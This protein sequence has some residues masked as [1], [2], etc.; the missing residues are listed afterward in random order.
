MSLPSELLL[1]V[2]QKLNYGFIY[3]ILA[4][5]LISTTVGSATITQN[6]NALAVLDT[7]TTTGSSATLQSR[8]LVNN[9]NGLGIIAKFTVNFSNGRANTTQLIG[10]GD[11]SD[12]GLFFGYNG[13]DFGIL[14]RR[15][16]NDTWIN[17]SN[18][19]VSDFLVF[20]PTKGNTYQIRFEYR[21]LGIIEFGIED[22]AGKFFLV[23][24][25]EFQINFTGVQ[26]PLL[27]N[28]SMSFFAKVDNSSTTNDL[29]LK[30]ASMLAYSI[31]DDFQLG[32][33]WSTSNKTTLAIDTEKLIF[34]IR[35]RPNFNA[36]SN[37]RALQLKYLSL[38]TD[39]TKPVIF[40]IY[41]QSTIT[42][43]TWIDI[44]NSNSI[45]EVKTSGTR[46]NDFFV[47]GLVLSKDN[48]GILPLENLNLVLNPGE[49]LAVTGE[50]GAASDVEALLTWNEGI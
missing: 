31:G 28:S 25:I 37:R 14:Y 48:S 15:R 24:R 18:W 17:R 13:S 34:A 6:A 47:T 2:K 11:D 4:R 32:L 29:T 39:G 33:P 5:S 20:D 21:G 23:H 16:G 8:R 41:I 3:D 22:A 10:L 9:E 26:R 12:N 46:S 45:V 38:S 50:S 36:E 27:V 1:P 44:D 40:K 35:N 49:I 30:I 19:N 42:G 43:G 7:G